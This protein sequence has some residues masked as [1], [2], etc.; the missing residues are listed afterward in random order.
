MRKT[1]ALYGIEAR[2]KLEVGVNKVYN[3]V[4]HTMGAKGRNVIYKKYGMPIVTNDGVSI[5]REIIPED[6]YEYL[7][8]ES[9]KQSAE[10]TNYD[11]GDGPQPLSAK[12]L[13]PNGFTTMGDIK[14]GDKICGSEGTT[15]SVVDVFEKGKA[16]AA[17]AASIFHFGEIPVPV[18][19]KELFEKGIHVRV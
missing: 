13:T 10:Q 1:E 16:D 17:L 2:E 18:L 4:C 9:I 3:A 7:G 6:P 15:Q 14:P 12:I 19:K 5:A 11:A 8:A